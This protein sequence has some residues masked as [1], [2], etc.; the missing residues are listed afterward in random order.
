MKAVIFEKVDAPL[1]LVDMAVP[2]VPAG[3]L[4]V[5]V[6]ACGIC[7]SDLHAAQ[8]PGMLGAGTVPGHEFAGEVVEVGAG[9][10][11]EFRPGDRVVALPFRACG[12]CKACLAGRP[13]NCLKPAAQGFNPAVAG[14]YAEYTVCQ[15]VMALKLPE[16]ISYADAALI[17]PFAVALAAWRQAGALAG[18]DVLI[19]GAG[20]IGLA[21][22]TWARFFG[23]GTIAISDLVPERLARATEAVADVVIDASSV[24]DPVAE[25]R[26]LADAEP[27]VIFECVG[28][29]MVQK[30]IDMAPRGAHLVFA[31]ASLEPEPISVLSATVKRL[32]MS[33]AFA[34][35][36]ADFVFALRMLANQRIHVTPFISATISLDQ[37]PEMFEALKRPNSQCKVLVQA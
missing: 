23:A 34:Y 18:A 2:S 7:G 26:N 37:L 17:E 11:K 31:G 5:R 33:F 36:R 8:T 10:D 28:R 6:H 24:K 29:P 27:S 13:D 16:T 19:L 22:A 12:N 3:C 15:A 9:A 30:V 14:A 32:R 25:F 35:E 21:L 4:K 20:V 1:A